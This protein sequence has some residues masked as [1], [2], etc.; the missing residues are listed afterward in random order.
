VIVVGLAVASWIIRP[1]HR[2]VPAMQAVAGGDLARRAAPAGKNE[3]G[4][5]TSSFNSMAAALQR[6]RSEVEE[7]YFGSL[8]AFARAIDARDNY[9]FEHSARVAAISL[10]I[11]DG[12]GISGEERKALR[13]SGLLHDI[14]KIGVQDQI[15]LKAGPLT[16][17]EWEQIRRH[18]GIGFDIL[19]DIGFLKRSL[20]GV[21]HHHERWDG[22][23][24]P[25][26]LRGSVIPQQ[27]RIISVADAF[28]AM[29]SDRAYRKGYSIDFAVATI[30]QGAGSQFDPESVRA[31]EDRLEAILAHLRQMSKA[32]MPQPAEVHWREEE[33]A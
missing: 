8:D 4:V 1:I 9:T 3:I 22:S 10:E 14:G 32:P 27:A 6:S 5:L 2:L 28:D 7:A 24:Y 25:D 12:M 18:P 17:E 29:T 21:R 19:K 23:G 20:D 15:L 11:A 31:F 26:G 13:R 33:A 16:E 30:R